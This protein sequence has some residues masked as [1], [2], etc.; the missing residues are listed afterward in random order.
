FSVES[1]SGIDG[2]VAIIDSG[3]RFTPP[4]QTTGTAVIELTVSGDRVAPARR[5]LVIDVGG[6]SASQ[7]PDA[8]DDPDPTRPHYRVD[9]ATP[10]QVALNVLD[11]DT[12]AQG[13]PLTVRLPAATS[14]LG[15]QLN[16]SADGREVL[17][18]IGDRPRG[19]EPREDVDA[20]I[21]QACNSS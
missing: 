14:L 13:R 3:L 1:V 11:N 17:Y 18:E 20:F 21:Y 19:A 15:A 16:V 5:L 4:P 12:D 6:P 9:L 2:K 10:A 8:H 7:L